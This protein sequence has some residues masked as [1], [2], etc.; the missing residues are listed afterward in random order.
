MWGK[1]KKNNEKP[2]EERAGRCGLS[3]KMP[4]CLTSL[5]A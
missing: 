3:D 5:K 1:K 4:T 2:K